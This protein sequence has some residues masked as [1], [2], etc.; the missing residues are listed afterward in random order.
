MTIAGIDH[1]AVPIENVEEMLSFYKSLGFSVRSF[2]DDDLPVHAVMHGAVRL[3]FH[4]PTTWR[5]ADFP[6]GP[7]ALP[8]CGDFCFVWDGVIED[9]IEFVSARGIQIEFGPVERTGARAQSQDLGDSI[10]FRDPDQ[11]LLELIAYRYS[12]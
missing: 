9:A 4:E 5:N 11:N 2:G 8:G 1:A 10:Y 3:N 12:A 6:R 7:Y